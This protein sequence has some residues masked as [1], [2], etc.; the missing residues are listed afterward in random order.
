MPPDVARPGELEAIFER[1]RSQWGRLDLLVHSIA[2]APKAD[3][4]LAA[5]ATEC[6]R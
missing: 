6:R 1:I 3:L 5:P 4:H 2:C